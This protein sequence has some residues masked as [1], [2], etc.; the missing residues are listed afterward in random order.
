MRKWLGILFF[1][2]PSAIVIAHGASNL[3]SAGDFDTRGGSHGAA[4]TGESASPVSHTI[5]AWGKD[6]LLAHGNIASEGKGGARSKDMAG[7]DLDLRYMDWDRMKAVNVASNG[8]A[9]DEAQVQKDEENGNG[10]EQEEE[11][12]GGWDRLWDSPKLG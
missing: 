1:V 2:F 8:E 5:T 10:E 3:P 4:L 6:L 11:E 12:G 9:S 7:S